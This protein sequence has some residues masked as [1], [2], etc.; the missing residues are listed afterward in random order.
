VKHLR[1]SF[2]A[3]SKAKTSSQPA[4]LPAELLDDARKTLKVLKAR[5]LSAVTAES[6]TAGAGICFMAASSPIQKPL[7]I[8]SR[9]SPRL[10]RRVG[11]VS[12]PVASRLAASALRH[13]PADIAIAETGVRAPIRTRMAIRPALSMR[14]A[15]A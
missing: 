7:S 11:S 5:G 14:P 3:L 8:A 9:C 4:C 13:S 6:C 15:P 1:P 12:Q 2:H 10:L